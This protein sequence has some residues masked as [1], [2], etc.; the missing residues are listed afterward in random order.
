MNAHESF[1]MFFRSKRDQYLVEIRKHKNENKLLAKRRKL[2]SGSSAS[3]GEESRVPRD[4]QPIDRRAA[5]ANMDDIAVSFRKSLDSGDYEYIADVAEC[6]RRLVSLDENPPLLELIKTNIVPLIVKLLDSE[7]FQHQK[8]MTECSWI[9]VNLASGDIDFVYYLVEL[10]IIPKA[11]NLL[12]HPT[13][14]VRENATWIL[15]NIG[16]ENLE[17]R[18]QLLDNDVVNL[19]DYILRQNDCEELPLSFVRDISWLISIILRGPEFPKQGRVFPLYKY[20]KNFLRRYEDVVVIKHTLW[21]IFY[22]SDGDN[23]QI[24]E[25]LAMN[26]TERIVEL[27]SADDSD[28]KNTSLKIIGNL[29]SGLDHQTQVLIDAGV[30][31][32]L[33]CFLDSNKKQFRKI[34][35]WGLSN[36]MAGNH[37]QLDRVLNYR[38][39]AIIKKLFYII[40]HDAVEIAKE[41][42]ICLA[43]A[44]S[45]ATYEQIDQLVRFDVVAVFVR[46]LEEN[47]DAKVMKMCLEALECILSEYRQNQNQNQFVYVNQTHAG[48]M[49]LAQCG[50]VQIIENLQTHADNEVYAAVSRLIDNH[51]EFE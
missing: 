50:G 42:I 3:V 14:D 43:N 35:T 23:L 41:A 31:E 17:F 12:C 32:A 24:E 36:I 44:C 16:G 5:Q 22:I 27:L 20:L 28:I 6:I 29:L 30:I 9:L 39:S 40:D 21:S 37:L 18:N 19:I 26:C 34:A 51:F 47:G 48:M 8:L 10:D 11:L 7:Y 2:V 45:V 49:R 15:A 13:S 38:E 25:I 46:R 33:A 4:S 1:N